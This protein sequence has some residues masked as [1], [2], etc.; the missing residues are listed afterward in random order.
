[1]RIVFNLFP[2]SEHLYLPVAY[3]V[4]HDQDGTLTYMTQRAIPATLAPYGIEVTPDLQRLLELA[5]LLTPKALEAKF[6]PPKSKAPTPLAELLQPQN[7]AKSSVEAYLHRQLDKFYTEAVRQGYPLALD[8]EKRTLVKDVQ[9]HVATEELVPHLSFRRAEAAIEYRFQLGTE[10]QKFPISK[11]E[12]V[13]LTNTDPAWLLIDY[14]LFRVPGINGRMVNPFRKKDVVS[15]PPEQAKVYFKTF[16]ARNAGRNHIEA[17]GFEVRTAKD[18]LRTHLHTIE[19]ILQKTW[20]LKPVFEYQNAQFDHGDKRDNITTVEFEEQSD[21]VV[22]KK[23]TRDGP[24]EQ[25]RIAFLE[26]NG[27]QMEGRTSACP[28]PLHGNAALVWWVRWLA[29]HRKALEKAGFQLHLPQV[30]GKEV[31]LLPGTIEVHTEAR[32][33]WFDVYGQV[34]AGE[35][36]FGFK[37]LLPHLRQNDPLFPLPDGTYF[38]IPD[39]WFTRYADLAK[40]LRDTPDGAQLPKALFTLLGATG[41]ENLTQI[42]DFPI[43]DPETVDYSPGPELRAT[44]RPYQVYGVKWLIGHYNHGFGACLADSMGLGKTLQTIAVLLH[45]KSQRPAPAEQP[46]IV[47]PTPEHAAPDKGFQLDLFGPPAV[48]VAVPNMTTE[49]VTFVPVKTYPALVILPASL[50]FNWQKELE[51][52]A[53]SLFVRAHVGPQRERDPRVLAMHDVVLTTYH[54]ARLDLDMLAKVDWHFIILDESQQ[55]KNRDSEIS[56]VVRQLDAYHKISLSGT[57]IENSLADLWTQMEFINPST[58]GSYPAFREQFQLPIERQGDPVAREQLFGR[59]RPFFLRRTKEEVAPDLPPKIEQVFYSE[60][61]AAQRS[62]YEEIKSAVR[63]EILQL[64]D[65][66]K[67]RLLA[68]QALTRLRQLAN[69]PVLADKTYDGDSGKLDDVLAQWETVRRDG[70]KV[71]FF[72]SFTQHLEIFRSIFEKEKIPY[73]WLTGETPQAERGAIIERFQNDD[74][75]QAFFCSIKAGG[76]GLNLTAADYVFLLDPWWNPAA[77]DQAIARAHRIGQTKPVNAIRFISR[78]SIEEKIRVMQER[79]K[80]L[81]NELFATDNELPAFTREDI[82]ALIE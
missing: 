18:L 29:N 43:I 6:K 25:E 71:L 41:E 73:T 8:G 79:K 5:D 55:I 21:S 15:I 50:V 68:I 9:I 57:P 59:V 52:F 69:H 4:Q 35:F 11:H 36:T 3:L 24:S 64:F 82:L 54:T 49:Q 80:A 67:T 33:D 63:N 45:A 2:F 76:V 77:E 70:H 78:D 34:V 13:A 75:V 40:A 23:I 56:K 26:K 38:L 7:P 62:R 48:E 12:V 44:L 20:S 74:S 31:A 39:E 60:M 51:Q 32:N 47:L 61:S 1:M 17:E 42:A 19:D 53:P 81:S 30:D 37:D 72:S 65:D 28:E 66:P 22:V 46:P 10:A 16:I 27:L 14:A 58:L